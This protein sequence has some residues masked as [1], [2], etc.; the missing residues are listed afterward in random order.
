LLL[1]IFS[2]KKEGNP[3][4]F[5]TLDED[6][7]HYGKWNKTG[8]SRQLSHDLICRKKVKIRESENRMVVTRG[9]RVERDGSDAGQRY[10][11]YCYCSTRGTLWYLQKFLTMYHSWLHPLHHSPLFSTSHIPEF[12]QSHFSIF[13]HEYIMFPLHSVSLTLFLYPTPHWYQLPDRTC[14][15]FLFFLRKGIFVCLR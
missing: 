7:E 9:W 12:Q 15:T 8:M 14:F 13:I 5:T 11:S 3:S 10:Q 4:I 2:L 6:E 1:I